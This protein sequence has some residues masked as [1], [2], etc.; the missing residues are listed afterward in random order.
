MILCVIND[1]GFDVPGSSRL[2]FLV[3]VSCSS[4]VKKIC[5]IA[6]NVLAIVVF[7]ESNL[8]MFV[9]VHVPQGDDSSD[10]AKLGFLFCC[11][12]SMTRLS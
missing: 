5:R 8:I 1:F 12:R 11:A 4:L 3:H 2:A 10:F 6:G 7:H 9:N